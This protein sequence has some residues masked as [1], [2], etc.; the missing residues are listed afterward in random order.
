MK[1]KVK[2]H[3]GSS[4]E[5]IKKLNSTEYEV[6][7]KKRPIEGK[8]NLEMIKLLKKYFKCREIKIISGFSSKNKILEFVEK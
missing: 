3:P 5:K 2:I 1:I 8:A 7:L 6:W 4:Q